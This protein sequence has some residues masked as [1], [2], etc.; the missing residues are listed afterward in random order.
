MGTSVI[1]ANLGRGEG[2]AMA[3]FSKQN[4]KK[5]ATFDYVICSRY[6]IFDLMLS[7]DTTSVSVSKLWSIIM[8]CFLF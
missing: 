1:V 3:I 5:T 6:F 4:L 7:S 2:H 8:L